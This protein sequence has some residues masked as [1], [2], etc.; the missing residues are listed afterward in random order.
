MNATYTKM[1]KNGGHEYGSVVRLPSG[2]DRLV[3]IGVR[4]TYEEAFA[5]ASSLSKVTA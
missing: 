5:E 4:E 2:R 1:T 3:K